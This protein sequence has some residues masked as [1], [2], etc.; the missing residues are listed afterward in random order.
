MNYSCNMI[1]KA[2]SAA[3]V[4]FAG[5]V[6]V[7]AQQPEMVEIPAGTFVM[8]G[9]GTGENFDEAPAH[10]VTISAPFKMSATEITNAQYEL[11]DPSHK[12]LRGHY[13][14]ISTEDDEAVTMVS[15]ED[16][17]EYCRWLSSKT[18]KN[19][20]LPT[21]AEWEYA[22]RAG[23][24]TDF[25]TGAELDSLCMRNQKTMR[26]LKKV[27]LTV[28]ITPANP[29]GLKEMH[30]NVEEWC[31][32]WYGPYSDKIQTDP[33]GPSEGLYR[34]TRGGSH[35]T[36]VRYLR[37]R[38][39]MGALPLD[40]H[41]QIGFRIVES[42]ADLNHYD[43]ESS[44]IPRNMDAVSQ[45]T[46][47]WKKTSH[48]P[49]FMTPQVFVKA[50]DTPDTPFY[51]HNHQPAIT[52]CD[53]GDLLAVWFSCDDEKG[54]EQVVLASR[55][56]KGEKE[57]ENASLFLHVPDRNVTGSSLLNDGN[58]KLWHF[59]G[60]ANSGDWQNL[61]LTLR[62]ST[63]NGKTWSHAE[64]IEP[65]HAKRHQVVAGPI[66]T[67]DGTMIQ[68]CDAGPGG[69][70]EGTSVHISTD[71]GKTWSDPWNGEKMVKPEDG[72]TGPS[73]AGIH[74]AIVELADG[75]LM[76][77]G[78]GVGI[79]GNDG[80]LHLPQSFSADGGKSW[81]YR[82][83]PDFLPIWSGQRVTM[84]RLQEGPIMLV[85]FT[86]HPDKGKGE[87]YGMEFTDCDGNTFT[88][89]GMFVALSFDEGMTWPVRRLVTD[90]VER[91]L[92]GGAWTQEFTM[93]KT[94]A[95]TKGYLA[96]VQTP[97]GMIHLISSR[98]HYRFNL[99]WILGGR[100]IK[101][102]QK[103]QPGKTH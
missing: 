8:G 100:K 93:D 5:P 48:K 52:W 1:L 44:V 56:R 4:L 98:I 89:Y 61:A 15:W 40:R 41:S 81:T 42:D 58:G 31:L 33:C 21:E 95:E 54:R 14:G 62:T 72:G 38:N 6:A 103:N 12:S 86:G 36:P 59:N 76:T 64:L 19:Y 102:F 37:S 26:N 39:R 82:A 70:P 3:T 29:F 30:G 94:H 96:S 2:V 68:T 25:W 35:N 60:I 20:R 77:V 88:G 85:S 11:F 66:I 90:G 71:K 34:V 50:P 9:P 57:W 63:D 73:I 55:L 53:N 32:D 87:S 23:S 46:A 10:R 28:G 101:D 17:S 83:M 51:S 78:R 99:A 13:W 24:D 69:G 22:C 67:S 75:R 84:R 97:D 7:M 16:A 65:E 45:K 74:G 80:K 27:P 49:V 92:N 18:G 47:T 43:S 79:T 91:T